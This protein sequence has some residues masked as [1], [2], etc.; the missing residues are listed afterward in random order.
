MDDQIKKVYWRKREIAKELRVYTSKLT[1]WEKYFGDIFC[2]KK[3]E[4]GIRLYDNKGV[5]LF[6]EVHRL[7]K[8]EKHTLEGVKQ[9]IEHLL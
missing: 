7:A 1:Y 2:S 8:V 9:K 4:R 5:E 3:T 6:K